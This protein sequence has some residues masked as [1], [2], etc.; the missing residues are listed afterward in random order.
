V[1]QTPTAFVVIGAS[2]E[3]LLKIGASLEE[4][5][6]IGTPTIAQERVTCSK[7]SLPV[8]VY[9]LRYAIWSLKIHEYVQS[10]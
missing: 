7:Q 6:K 1:N 5:L 10:K 9:V 2:L 8:S 3:E 4:L